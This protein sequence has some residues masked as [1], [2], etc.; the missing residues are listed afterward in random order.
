MIK[1]LEYCNQN[2]GRANDAN[3]TE[4][5][6]VIASEIESVGHNDYGR[7]DERLTF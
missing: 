7:W 2:N 6:D 1:R 3:K 4:N 5:G